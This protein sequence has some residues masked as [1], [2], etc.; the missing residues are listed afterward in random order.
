MMQ[1]TGQLPKLTNYPQQTYDLNHTWGGDL[2][3]SATDD[4]DSVTS[5]TK[6]QQR[7]YRRLMTNPLTSTI[8]PDYIWHPDYGAGL[9]AKVGRALSSDL[10]DEIMSTTQAQMFLEDSV[11]RFPAPE[12]LLQT[13][14]GGLFEQIN[15]VEAISQQPVVLTFE[16]P[17]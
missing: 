11:A 16:V 12:V 15:Y 9:P 8:P 14:Q 6:S 2:V 17:V 7:I 13:I 3:L 10:Y 4:L 5:S 1:A